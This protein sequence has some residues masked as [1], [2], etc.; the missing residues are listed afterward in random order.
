[1]GRGAQHHAVG[2]QE[3]SLVPQGGHR[4]SYMGMFTACSTTP[5]NSP[6]KHSW[7]ASCLLEAYSHHQAWW[8]GSRA[9][10]H[11]ASHYPLHGI[12]LGDFS[13]SCEEQA[14]RVEDI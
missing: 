7:R 3:W 14:V 2:L 4:S 12:G 11:R 13:C 1:M 10:S 5:L 8:Q 6:P 9:P